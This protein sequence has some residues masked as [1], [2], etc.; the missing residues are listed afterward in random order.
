MT[1][2]DLIRTVVL[3]TN[4]VFP[5][6]FLNRIPYHITLKTFTLI[7][8]SY[9]EI[10]SIY[11]RHGMSKKN[12]VPAISDIDITV[13]ISGNLSFE[14]E[15]NL[16]K[17]LW[18]KFDRLKKVFL[19]LGEV[20]ILN[21][22]EIEEW[23]RYTIRGYE[24]SGWRLLYGKE[25]IKSN[26][27]NEDNVLAIDSLN[28]ALTSYLE[29]FLPKF[30][31]EGGSNY[32]IQKEL[33]RLA[34]KILRYAGVPFEENRK[35]GNKYELL[36]TV[37][38]GL[39]S[40]VDKLNYED[41]EAVATISLKNVVIR[42]SDLKYFPDVDGLSK[43]HDKIE[44][45]I[46]TYTVQFIIL[47]DDLELAETV[48]LLNAIRTTFKSEA[49]KPVIFNFKIFEYMLRI[50]NPFFYSQ[51]LD[52]R[53]V[54]LG[55][56]SFIKVA[57]PDLCFYR[58][59]LIDDISNIFLFARNK[60]LIQHKT[61]HRFIENEFNSIVNRTL[62]LKLCLEKASLEIMF[63]NSLKECRKNYPG[64]IQR[65]D[66]IL[67]NY[68]TIDSEQLSKDAFML[69]RTLTGDVYDSLV[70]SEAHVINQEN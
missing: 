42:D 44:S 23:S 69:L 10:K 41:T 60:S 12:W 47:K 16:L 38:K 37:I 48:D 25:V 58:K 2:K 57:K 51:L 9:S 46:I 11:L 67:D 36:K 4:S 63:D 62:F 40:G 66:F 8:G 68:K 21:E 65:L 50:Y 24:T 14:K 59:A 18:N 22:R 45:F 6:N 31:S 3:K 27:A 49:I 56:D 29:Y 32:L 33:T 28:F 53:K 52:Q 13:I 7:I 17:L 61:V 54:L 1:I 30:Y 15:F 39:E 70:S 26:Y 34:S 35:G 5:F 64:Q 43:H 20:D 55:E 19:M